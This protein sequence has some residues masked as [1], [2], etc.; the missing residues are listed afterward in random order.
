M[1]DDKKWDATNFCGMWKKTSKN[2]NVYMSSVLTKERHSDMLRQLL[3]DLE[4][5]AVN[6]MAFKVNNKAK[7]TSADWSLSYSKIAPATPA[8]PT[9]A[10]PPMT[11]AVDDIPF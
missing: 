7:E 4:D 6:L 10:P 1:S 2:G 5:G 3:K 8:E 9:Q 11:G